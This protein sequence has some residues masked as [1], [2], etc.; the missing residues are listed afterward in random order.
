MLKGLQTQMPT[1]AIWVTYRDER[2]MQK[3]KGEKVLSPMKGIQIQD[4]K[5]PRQGNKGPCGP[6]SVQT[7]PI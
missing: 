2:R 7:L 4:F 5:T 6:D 3:R 1:V